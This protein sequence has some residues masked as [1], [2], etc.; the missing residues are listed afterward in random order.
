[1]RNIRKR[2]IVKSKRHRDPS[3]RGERLWAFCFL[4]PSIAGIAVFFY[5]AIGASVYFSFTRYKVLRPPRW[6]G[7][8]NYRFLLSDETFRKALW[9]TTKLTAVGVPLTIILALALA[10]ALNS[11]IRFQGF[12]RLIFFMPLVSMPVAAAAVWRWLYSPQYGF[13]DQM[14]GYVGFDRVEW[15]SRPG[16]AL[17]AVMAMEI[18]RQTGLYLLIL[19]A[20]LQGIPKMYY[21][22]ATVDGANTWRQFRHVTLPL[23]TPS[24][25]F[26][27][28]IGGIQAFQTFDAVIIMT[29]RGGPLDSTRTVMFDIYK[30]AFENF[31]MGRSATASLVLLVIILAFTVAQFRMQRRWVH[32]E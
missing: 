4:A 1:M 20:G 7:L 24:I 30:D 6:I 9:N 11:K 23:L 16:T 22:A 29:P 15:L 13:F 2:P 32:Y 18:W 26:L 12:Y 17:W 8:D 14:L 3:Q 25:F 5:I 19:L 10:V 21:E 27:V 28:V 31:R